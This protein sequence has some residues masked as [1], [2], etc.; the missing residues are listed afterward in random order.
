MFQVQPPYLIVNVDTMILLTFQT[1]IYK[2]FK[3]INN[4]EIQN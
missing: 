2:N 1:F 3:Y 4:M